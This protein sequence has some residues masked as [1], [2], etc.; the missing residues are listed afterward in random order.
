M[1]APITFFIGLGVAG[2]SSVQYLNGFSP[3]RVL[4]IAIGLFFMVFGWFVGWTK[5]RRFTVLL[6]HLATTAGCL[7]TAYAVYQL[8]S[9]QSSPTLVEVLDL[10]LFWGL[11]TIFGGY[12]MITHGYCA[13]C[14]GQHDSRR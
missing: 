5:H 3:I 10:P 14:I 4:G 12:C 13:C 9:M 8:P 1:K 7:V 2:L 6:G 11:F